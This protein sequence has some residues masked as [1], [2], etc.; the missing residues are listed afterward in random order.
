MDHWMRV[1]DWFGSLHRFVALVVA[2]L[3]NVRGR[4]DS[5]PSDNATGHSNL[6]GLKKVE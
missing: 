6:F 1:S 2:G 4:L 5:V 3:W